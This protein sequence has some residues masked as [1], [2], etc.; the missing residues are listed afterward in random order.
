MLKV[1]KSKTK[2]TIQYAVYWTYDGAEKEFGIVGSIKE[3]K[4]IIRDIKSDIYYDT[5]TVYKF[6]PFKIYKRKGYKKE[7]W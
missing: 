7:D 6:T 4:E 2:E 5:I 1:K 3:A